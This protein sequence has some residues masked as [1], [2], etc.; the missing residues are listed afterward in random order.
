MISESRLELSMVSYEK[1]EHVVETSTGDTLFLLPRGEWIDTLSSDGSALCLIRLDR[2]RES[3]FEY[4]PV[5]KLCRVAGMNPSPWAPLSQSK[6]LL[7]LLDNP[8]PAPGITTP[9]VA[10]AQ[11]AARASSTG[12]QFTAAAGL[13]VVALLLWLMLG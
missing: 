13:L 5:S 4:Q 6:L 10:T 11:S 1:Y 12:V 2:S 7:G 8:S 9:A 3:W